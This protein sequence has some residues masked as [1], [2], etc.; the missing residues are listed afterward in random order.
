MGSHF[1]INTENWIL[2][3][4]VLTLVVNGGSAAVSGQCW[5]CFSNAVVE[6]ALVLALGQMESATTEGSRVT[7]TPGLR[8][9]SAMAWR[10]VTDLEGCWAIVPVSGWWEVVDQRPPLLTSSRVTSHTLQ[11][12][13]GVLC[14]VSS[15]SNRS[16]RWDS[17]KHTGYVG[18]KNQGATCY[19]NSLLQTLFFTNQLR[20]VNGWYFFPST[21]L[22]P[23]SLSC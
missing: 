2:C 11:K 3:I 23:I 5:S 10:R 1:D 13:G 8:I 18:L 12:Q 20:K 7:R 21:F 22:P 14:S 15:T 9:L 16:C 17:K 6:F 19:M 4:W